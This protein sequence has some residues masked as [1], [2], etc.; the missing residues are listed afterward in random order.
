[1]LFCLRCAGD[2]KELREEEIRCAL[3]ISP[4]EFLKTKNYFID[5]GFILQDFSVVNWN[6]RQ[7][8]SDDV[9]QRVQR[10]R[11]KVKRYS[12][13]TE[14]EMKRPCNG[15]VTPPDTDTDTDTEVSTPLVLNPKTPSNGAKPKQEYSDEFESA[16]KNH[17]TAKGSKFK[18][19]EKWKKLKRDKVLPPLQTILE[20]QNR[21]RESRE[22]REGYVPHFTTW[23]N[24]RLWEEGEGA[25][26][27][28]NDESFWG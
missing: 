22:W 24:G 9:S 27:P 28:Q 18:A 5:R 7:F 21:Q 8:I 23:L 26:E 15:N 20:V 13:V 17:G 14:T 25:K 1:M 10:H 4:Q 12:N 19:Y 16:W 11:E 3:R 6:K 2:L